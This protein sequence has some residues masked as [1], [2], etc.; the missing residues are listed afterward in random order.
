MST[1]IINEGLL[2][3]IEWDSCGAHAELF[4]QSIKH[5]FSKFSHYVIYPDKLYILF[6]SP[7]WLCSIFLAEETFLTYTILRYIIQCKYFVI[8][9]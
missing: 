9:Q 6:Y 4:T 8:T 2:T 1:H 3:S 7:I 5:I